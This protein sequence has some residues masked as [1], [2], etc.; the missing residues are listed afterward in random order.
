MRVQ[1]AGR[2]GAGRRLLNSR[3]EPTGGFGR[4]TDAGHSDSYL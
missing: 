1:L 3:S 4:V 2:V